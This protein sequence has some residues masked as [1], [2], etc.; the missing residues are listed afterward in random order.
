MSNANKGHVR[1]LLRNVQGRPI[2]D[3][4]EFRFINQT[5]RARDREFSLD[6]PDL[7]RDIPRLELPAQP[8]GIYQVFINPDR[9][10]HSSAFVSVPSRRTT[11]LDLV[12]FIQPELARTRFPSFE[13]LQEDAEWADLK[14]VLA[15]TPLN[16]EEYDALTPLQKG[17]LFNLHAK[18]QAQEVS[19]GARVF[20]FVQKLDRIQEDRL[21]FRAAPELLTRTRAHET[22]FHTVP[23]TLH[24]GFSDGFNLEISFKTFE[25]VGN[26]QLTFARNAAGELQVDADL[27][28]RQGL[29]HAFD[30]LQHRLTG[31]KTHPFDIHQVLIRFQSIDPGYV[32]F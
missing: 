19:N 20:S 23:G 16:A 5:L 1:P 29:L 10:R 31:D 9:Y 12:F 11:D 30:V 17:T 21:F 25:R 15:A 24:K 4:V 7:I 6:I 13:T 18:M 32:L 26:L 28:D 2:N 22:G 14:R 27:D 3:H 8:H